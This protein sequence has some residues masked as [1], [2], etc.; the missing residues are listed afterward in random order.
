MEADEMHTDGNATAGL[1]QEIFMADFTMLEHACVCG[2]RNP[3]GAHRCYQGAG[4]VLRCPTCGAVGLRVAKLPDRYVVE[5][6]G[7]WSQR[8]EP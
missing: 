1:L 2:D 4:I 8:I 3:G 7:A 6:R 5:L